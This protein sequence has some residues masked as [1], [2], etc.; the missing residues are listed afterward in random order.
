MLVLRAVTKLSED[1]QYLTVKR[2]RKVTSLLPSK[3]TRSG[4]AANSAILRL[5]IRFQ[6]DQKDIREIVVVHGREMFI[7]AVK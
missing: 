6:L 1:S 2:G 7:P 4:E 3:G 5:N